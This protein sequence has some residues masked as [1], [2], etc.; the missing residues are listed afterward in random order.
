MYRCI[1]ENYFNIKDGKG[2]ILPIIYLVTNKEV[3]DCSTRTCHSMRFN[4]MQESAEAP[5]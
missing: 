5:S 4:W 1:A 2:Y 3:K